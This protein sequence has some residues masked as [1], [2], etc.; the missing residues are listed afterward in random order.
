M[1]LIYNQRTNGSGITH[2]DQRLVQY[3][4][5]EELLD[6]SVALALFLLLVVLNVFEKLG[7]SLECGD[8]SS[9]NPQD[10]CSGLHTPWIRNE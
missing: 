2:L 6:F 10:F 3:F 9:D 1:S 7:R 5:L 4:D 8:N